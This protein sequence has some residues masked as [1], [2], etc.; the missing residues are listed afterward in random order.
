MKLSCLFY[1]TWIHTFNLKAFINPSYAPSSEPDS[2][3]TMSRGKMFWSEATHLA[4]SC[5]W[6]AGGSCRA[7]RSTGR[8]RARSSP[9]SLLQSWSS[10]L[11]GSASSSH[12]AEGEDK[13]EAYFIKNSRLL[14]LAQQCAACCLQTHHY[15]AHSGHS[16]HH[17]LYLKINVTHSTVFH[18]NTRWWSQC[19][20]AC[21]PLNKPGCVAVGAAVQQSS[22]LCRSDAAEL[23]WCLFCLFFW[24]N[25]HLLSQL[26]IAG[27][28]VIFH[29]LVCRDKH[30]H[31]SKTTGKLFRH[32]EQRLFFMMCCVSPPVRHVV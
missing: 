32:V 21:L 19:L 26:L 25:I 29:A 17:H 7:R 6:T 2:R 8:S 3:Q 4:L 12:I 18:P 14:I 9:R 16:I 15:I 31:L 24:H 1:I 28:T 27:A 10:Y 13:V 30:T 23:F 20:G 5:R 22:C 11:A